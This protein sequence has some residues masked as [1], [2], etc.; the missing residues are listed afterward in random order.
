MYALYVKK[1]DKNGKCVQ[2]SSDQLD[3]DRLR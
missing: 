3:L 1:K 2:L